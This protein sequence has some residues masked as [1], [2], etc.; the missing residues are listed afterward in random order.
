MT[1]VTFANKSNICYILFHM[2]KIPIQIDLDQ[3]T[4]LLYK[5]YASSQGKS[6]SL[7]IRERLMEKKLFLEK[8][9]HPNI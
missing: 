5:Q 6:F 8:Q 3:D 2:N 4:V 1:Y 7:V 9:K